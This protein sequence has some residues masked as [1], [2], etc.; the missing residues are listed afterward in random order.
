M[1]LFRAAPAWKDEG[2]MCEDDC[3]DNLCTEEDCNVPGTYAGTLALEATWPL[4]K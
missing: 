4:G 3:T 2:T 1:P